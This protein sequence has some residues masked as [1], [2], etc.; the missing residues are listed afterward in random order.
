MGG[1]L[2]DP[3]RS[4]KE[5]ADLRAILVINKFTD[6]PLSWAD[7]THL[8]Q[9]NDTGPSPLGFHIWKQQGCVVG[10]GCDMDQ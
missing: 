2:N 5:S 8:E 1:A 10:A 3:L 4:W 7:P 6:F 9:L